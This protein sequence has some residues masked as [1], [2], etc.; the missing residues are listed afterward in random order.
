MQ[1]R[2]PFWAISYLSSA[3]AFDSLF[4]ISPLMN[5][6]QT[7]NLEFCGGKRLIK[8]G[9]GKKRKWHKCQFRS[10]TEQ[11]SAITF[12]SSGDK[13]WLIVSYM[14]VPTSLTN[15]TSSTSAQSSRSWVVCIR[16]LI[17]NTTPDRGKH[18]FH[19]LRMIISR[20]SY[21]GKYG[22]MKL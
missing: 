5:D 6:F 7:Q 2:A 13:K 8:T 4:W 12:H 15:T 1:S 16:L 20:I 19:P 17:P 14:F 11:Y 10:W 18:T 9:L 22:N 3:P 21:S